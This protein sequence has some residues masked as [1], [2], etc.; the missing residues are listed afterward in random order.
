MISLKVTGALLEDP[1]A[2]IG[3]FLVI[4]LKWQFSGICYKEGN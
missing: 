3:G 1:A 4:Q 2:I